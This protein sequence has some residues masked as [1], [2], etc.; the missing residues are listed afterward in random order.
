MA[1]I[2]SSSPSRM[3]EMRRRWEAVRLQLAARLA[4]RLTAAMRSRMD[5]TDSLQSIVHWRR[6]LEVRL[7]GWDH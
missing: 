6:V 7:E 1:S 4:W 2:K 5:A 3:P